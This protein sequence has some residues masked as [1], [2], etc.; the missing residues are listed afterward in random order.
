VPLCHEIA[1]DKTKESVSENV[2]TMK[3]WWCQN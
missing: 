3:T 1:Y 2:N